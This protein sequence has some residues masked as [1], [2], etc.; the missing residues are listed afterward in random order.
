TAEPNSSPVALTF[1]RDVAAPATLLFDLVDDP[2]AQRAWRDGLV[3]TV[4]TSGHTRDAPVGATFVQRVRMAGR[5]VAWQV[6]ILAWERPRRIAVRVGVGPVR[7][8]VRWRFEALDGGGSRLTWSAE[9]SG[10]GLLQRLS[11][12]AVGFF[13]ARALAGQVAALA[14]LAERRARKGLSDG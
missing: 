3:D 8:D 1:T 7:V 13:G 2:E 6:E 14:A 10:G 11:G 5:L 12:P 4:A 9:P